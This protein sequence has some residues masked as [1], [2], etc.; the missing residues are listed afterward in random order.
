MTRMRKNFSGTMKAKVAM[1]ALKGDK[2]IAQIASHYQIHVS[3]VRQWKQRVL[4][5]LPLLFSR[6]RDKQQ[7]DSQELVAEL[8]R[9]IGQ[10]KVELDWLKKS[11]THSPEERRRGIDPHHP[12]IS[13]TRQCELLGVSRASYY[14]HPKGESDSNVLLMNLIDEQYTR[15]PFY[16]IRRIREWLRTQGHVVNRKRIARL[17][18]V[19]GLEAIYPRPRLSQANEQHHKY[20]YL[21][22][23][24]QIEF[25][26]QVWSIDITY[27]RLRQGFVYLVAILDWFSRYVVSWNISPSMEV[28]FC[29]EALEHALQI[30]Q[31]VIFNSDQGSQFTSVDFTSRLIAAGIQ[32]SMDGRGRV[33]DN[34]FVERLWRTVKYEEVYL[35]SYE[36]LNEC[37]ENL[38]GYLQFYNDER[39]HQSLGY[40][41]P[42]QVYRNH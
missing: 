19:M 20:P 22:K 27:I 26:N 31:P 17:M 14:Y 13:I 7:T 34:I 35:K 37:R 4:D 33:F 29:L 3:Q 38:A 40:R 21:L 8:Y 12:Q 2:T 25:P 15:T 11:L 30:N 10:L 41:T 6:N 5:E 32:I 42:S 39:L 9:Q 1:E 28:E 16:G 23:G 36:N 18:R 24:V